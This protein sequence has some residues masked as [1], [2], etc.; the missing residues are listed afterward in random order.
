MS[1]HHSIEARDIADS[2]DM[3]DTVDKFD[4]RKHMMLGIECTGASWNTKESHWDVRF[5]DLESGLEYSRHAAILISAVGGISFPRDVKFQGMEKFKGDM[6]HTAKWNH[7][8]DYSG[9]RMAIIGNGCS[10]AQVVPNVIGK[11]AYVKQ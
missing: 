10:A 3:N 11:A 5:R 9:K 1:V 2:S 8:Y 6:F 7:G 4:L